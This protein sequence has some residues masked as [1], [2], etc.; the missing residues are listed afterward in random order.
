M[1][2]LCALIEFS[3]LGLGL[4]PG[5][6]QEVCR[7]DVTMFKWYH[8]LYY[9]FVSKKKGSYKSA[10]GKFIEHRLPP[11]L[12]RC[13]LLFRAIVQKH[14][15]YAPQGKQLLPTMPSTRSYSVIHLAKEIFDITSES[16]DLYHIRHFFH[17]TINILFPDG[18]SEYGVLVASPQISR[19]AGHSFQTTTTNYATL[20]ENWYD[21]CYEEFF[22]FMGDTDMSHPNYIPSEPK[23]CRFCGSN[24]PFSVLRQGSNSTFCGSNSPFSVLRQG[25]KSPFSIFYLYCGVL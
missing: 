13:L 19:R 12:E 17:T 23:C 20:R 2:K 15:T 10:A 25:S 5:R 6:F 11:C 21:G 24:S 22:Y 8:C 3:L 1:Q 14:G 4:A 16:L 9:G 18:A 7:L